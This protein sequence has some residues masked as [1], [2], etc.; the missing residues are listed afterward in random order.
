MCVCASVLLFLPDKVCVFLVSS[1]Q[2][3]GRGPSLT[4]PSTP[5]SSLAQF[6]WLGWVGAGRLSREELALFLSFLSVP[7]SSV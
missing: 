6:P 7:G 5:L 2:T 4:S 1:S 3:L